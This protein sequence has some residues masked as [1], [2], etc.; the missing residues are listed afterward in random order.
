MNTVLSLWIAGP[1]L[2]IA[3][4]V[5]WAVLR[6]K[7][8]NELTRQHARHVQQQ[9]T[10]GLHVQQAKRQIGQLQHDLA[11]ARLQVKR[12]TLVA[13]TPVQSDSR[14]NKTLQSALDDA[15]ET[16]RRLPVDGF[17]DTRPFRHSQHDADLLLR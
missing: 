1:A 12:L 5:Q 9:Q 7:Y 13:A 8:R 3:V 2:G 11:A 6:T 10:M 15:W 14:A 16:S 17:A 4:I